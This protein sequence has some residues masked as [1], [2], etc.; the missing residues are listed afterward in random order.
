MI[1]TL[2]RVP[3]QSIPADWK[4]PVSKRNARYVKITI[5][6]LVERDISIDQERITGNSSPKFNNAL[7]AE[8]WLDAQ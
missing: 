6:D 7:D 3:V 4:I 8:K 2:D 5:E 1:T